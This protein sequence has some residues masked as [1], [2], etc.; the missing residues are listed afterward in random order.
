MSDLLHITQWLSPAFPLGSYAYSQGL[1]TAIADGSVRDGATLQSWVTEVLRHGSGAGDAVLL[2]R[3][4]GGEDMADM[5]EAMA[6][7]AERWCETR[8]QGTAL[9]KVLTELGYSVPQAALPVVLGVAARALDVSPRE[10]IALYLQA[11]A[12]N[13]VTVAVR[14]VPLGQ[15]EGQRVLA[16]LAPVISEVA[17]WAAEAQIEDLTLA[18]IG[19]DQASMRHAEAEVRMF[20][21]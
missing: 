14:F 17:D 18:T 9:A 19:A 15:T 2:A 11:M 20:K 21:T 5:A 3:A 6:G 1:E 4:H 10:V 7:S 8:D 12:G 13:L 16:A